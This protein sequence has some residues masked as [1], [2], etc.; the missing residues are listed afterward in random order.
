VTFQIGEHITVLGDPVLLRVVM[1]N[2]LANA[3]KYTAKKKEPRIVFGAMQ[4]DQEQVIF[5]QDNGA[6]FPREEAGRIFEAFHRLHNEK[7]FRGTGIGLATVKRIITRHNGRVWAEGDT[8]R[9]ATI[10]FTLPDSRD[11]DRSPE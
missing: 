1:Q 7:E 11:T 5:V 9:G 8:G 2:L 10:Y 6:G 3:W 4:Q